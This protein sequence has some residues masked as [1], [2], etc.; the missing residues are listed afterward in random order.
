MRHSL[1]D[2]LKMMLAFVLHRADRVPTPQEPP[3]AAIE[4]ETD[5]ILLRFARTLEAELMSPSVAAAMIP[6]LRF[7]RVF[8]PV[9]EGAL[10]RQNRDGG[11]R[12]DVH[13]LLEL[14]L[15]ELWRSCGR[16]AWLDGAFGFS[17]E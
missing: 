3:S 9:V 5:A 7:A 13:D 17:G 6:R 14:L 4:A 16:Q 2:L 11:G 8:G 10:K 1:D 12:A 15:V